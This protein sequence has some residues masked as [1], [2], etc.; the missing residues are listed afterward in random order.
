MGVGASW[1]SE[2]SGARWRRRLRMPPLRSGFGRLLAL[3]CLAAA[4]CGAASSLQ[5][6]DLPPESPRTRPRF[7][8][9]GGSRLSTEGPQVVLAFEVP[10][11]ELFFRPVGSRF[12][13]RFDLIFLLLRDGKQAGGEVFSETIE[14]WERADTRDTATEVRRVLP[15]DVRPGRYRAQVTLRE[16]AA[17]RESRAD[18]ELEVPDYRRLPV[19]LSTL[20]VAERTALVQ[21]DSIRSLPPPGWIL[22]H[23]YGEPLP[24]L[25]V[26]GEVYRADAGGAPT[27]LSWSILGGREEEVQ[28][29]QLT[30]PAKDRALFVLEPDF[31]ALW[32]GSYLLEVRV[33]A[34]GE[35]ARRRFP[36]QMSATA[37]ALE[38]DSEQSLELIELI[39]TDDEMRELR[40]ALASE[41]K[42]AW[43][44]FWKRRDPTPD[45]AQNEFRDEFFARVRH[46]NEHFS[47][48]G[49]GWRSDRGRIYIQHGPP[50][51]IESHPFNLDTPAYE[52]W[53]YLRLGRRYVFVD[54][55]GYGRFEL[56]SPGRL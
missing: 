13:S 31:S 15:L 21:G 50:D 44:R 16:P 11:A 49:P 28:R 30:L 19:S 9:D 1:E 3:T 18:W 25:S 14:L 7:H 54:Y 17:G 46:A 43:N 42:E 56:Y 34:D 55:D 20:W 52:I 22:Q 32:I 38:A 2:G 35:T 37:R 45:T 23:E 53:I 6:T 29:G 33:E 51:Q 12:E 27:Q 24:N 10:Y 26:V 48:L 5:V 8:V 39:A 47:V 40:N 36:F 41:R 4:G